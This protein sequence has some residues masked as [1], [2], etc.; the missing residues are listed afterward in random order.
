MFLNIPTVTDASGPAF[1]P[2]EPLNEQ[3]CTTATFR[4]HRH[5]L[6]FPVR[7]CRHLKMWYSICVIPDVSSQPFKHSASVVTA[8]QAV[9]LIPL[10]FHLSSTKVTAQRVAGSPHHYRHDIPIKHT[11]VADYITQESKINHSQGIWIIQAWM[12]DK[13]QSGRAELPYLGLPFF[14]PPHL[15]ILLCFNLSFF[16]RGN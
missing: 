16:L 15:F 5:N 8:L 3:F 13:A 9:F 11:D 7:S 1:P 2:K 12:A 6:L 4:H 14:P 10:W